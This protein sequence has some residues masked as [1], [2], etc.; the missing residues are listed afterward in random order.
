MIVS[1]GGGES[2]DKVYSYD[3]TDSVRLTNKKYL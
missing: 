2:N 3:D 1:I